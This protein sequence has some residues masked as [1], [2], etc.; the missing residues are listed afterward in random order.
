MLVPGLRIDRCAIDADIAHGAAAPIEYQVGRLA[1]RG[2]RYLKVSPQYVGTFDQ[3]NAKRV[4]DIPVLLGAPLR[5]CERNAGFEGRTCG[6]GHGEE[7]GSGEQDG[8][9][10]LKSSAY[11]IAPWGNG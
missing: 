10:R 9:H 2:Y 8:A 6:G 3:L 5:E 11:H 7:Q 4:P 1:R